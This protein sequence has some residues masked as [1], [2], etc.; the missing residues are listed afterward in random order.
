M[1]ISSNWL[2]GSETCD[3]HQGGSPLIWTIIESDGN[4]VGLG[5]AGDECT[6]RKLGSTSGAS[7]RGCGRG[8]TSGRGPRGRSRGRVTIA[9]RETL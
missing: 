3:R 1:K 6:K 9:T 5:A 2:Y 8:T 7:G 4:R